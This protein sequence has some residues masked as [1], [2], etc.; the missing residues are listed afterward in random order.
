MSGPSLA[1]IAIVGCGYVGSRLAQRL[2]AD[3]HDVVGTTTTPKR[4][5]E[6]EAIGIPARL[7]R[8]DQ[9]DKLRELFADRRIVVCCAGAG[10]AGN[11]RSVYVDGLRSLMSA[12]TD[13]A[14][15]RVIYT[16]STR[17]YGQSDGRWVDESCA[18]DPS[19]DRG[20]VLLRAEGIL[21]NAGK[22][23]GV[24]STAAVVR[25]G[26][27]HGPGRALSERIRRASGEDMPGGNTFVNLIHVRDVVQ[28]LGLLCEST[29]SG[30]LNLVDDQPEP[31]RFL[32]DRVLCEGN[33]AP[34]RWIDT[35]GENESIGKRVRNALIKK[36]LGLHLEFPTHA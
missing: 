23:V 7:L 22:P 11:Y 21:L 8:L 36:T 3:G 2:L 35:A 6:L 10:R 29:Y 34:A 20:R 32:Y 17:V 33:L 15:R 9:T 5:T 24:G 28:A 1:R 12:A 27:I 18:P 31:R 26:G 30:V 14:V 4:Q 13:T 19:D 16:S 25:L